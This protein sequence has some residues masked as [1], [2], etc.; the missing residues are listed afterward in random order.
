MNT[1]TKT[2]KC[3]FSILDV[4]PSIETLLCSLSCP[5]DSE[6]HVLNYLFQEMILLSI[7]GTLK[8]F[9]QHN[10]EASIFWCTAF[11]MVQFSHPHRT[12]RKTTTLTIWTFVGKVMSLL[13]NMLPRF[14]IVFLPRSKTLL[15]P[16][17][18]SPSTMNLEPKKIKSVTVSTL[19]PSIYLPWSDGTRCHDLSFLNYEF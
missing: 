10:L 1:F 19:S 18:Q 16:W 9:L 11:L 17:L 3:L 13:F 4:S 14:V 2:L 15:I 8:S 6:F 12:T 7:Q 5:T